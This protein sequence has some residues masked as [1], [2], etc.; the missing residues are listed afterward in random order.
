MTIASDK[1]FRANRN[2]RSAAWRRSAELRHPGSRHD[3]GDLANA[4]VGSA[5]RRTALPRRHRHHR[6]RLCRRLRRRLAVGL[7]R[8][9][10]MRTRAL[11]TWRSTPPVMVR[12]L[13]GRPSLLKERISQRRSPGPG[14]AVLC[15]L[16]AP[17]GPFGHS[18]RRTSLR[19]PAELLPLCRL[20]ASRVGEL[21][22]RAFLG[23]QRWTV[24]PPKQVMLVTPFRRAVLSTGSP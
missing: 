14:L 6:R 3:S 5:L 23:P 11:R 20:P 16:P 15:P 12:P 2:S 22:F 8:T 4:A 10:H 9:K 13:R 7:L 19:C 18:A 24:P 21:R 17:R 1:V